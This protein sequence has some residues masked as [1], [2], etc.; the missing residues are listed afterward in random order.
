MLDE[1]FISF[2]IIG[3]RAWACLF[4]LPVVL[5]FWCFFSEFWYACRVIKIICWGHSLIS[6]GSKCWFRR[7]NYTYTFDFPTVYLLSANLTVVENSLPCA[8]GFELG[9]KFDYSGFPIQLSSIS[10]DTVVL[11]NF[12]LRVLVSL[13]SFSY[14]VMKLL[15][16]LIC[17]RISLSVIDPTMGL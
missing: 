14:F 11:R 15:C 16:I 17:S 1:L 7:F 5:Q 12:E 10:L 4:S 3:S 6:N 2:N 8:K 9:I 13:N